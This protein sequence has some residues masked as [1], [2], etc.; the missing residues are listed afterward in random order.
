M[1]I[2]VLDSS[3]RLSAQLMHDVH[4]RKMII[5][6]AQMLANAFS[7]E[8]LARSDVPRTQKG[9]IRKHSYLHH[10]CSQWVLRSDRN[11]SWLLEHAIELC[12]EYRRR[13]GKRH[14]TSEF[15]E[16]VWSVREQTDLPDIG[17]TTFALAVSKDHH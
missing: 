7:E 9:T 3:P 15:V 4:V 1:N 16:W 13:F 12:R 14:Y 11:F 10:P 6:S 17:K 2:F 5:E 8:R